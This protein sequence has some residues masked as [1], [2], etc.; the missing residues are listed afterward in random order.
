MP[1]V[2]SILLGIIFILASVSITLYLTHEY[3]KRIDQASALPVFTFEERLD[4]NVSILLRSVL[5]QN[6]NNAAATS[7]QKLNTTLQEYDDIYKNLDTEVRQYVSTEDYSS[8]EVA[9]K[10]RNI[11]LAEIIDKIK[12]FSHTKKP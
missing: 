11:L 12:S 9:K 3:G 1:C 7:L 4:S 8:A 10:K 6:S 2:R 5:T